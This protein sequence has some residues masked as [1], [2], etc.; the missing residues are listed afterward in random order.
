MNLLLVIII[1]IILIFIA[2]VALS[3]RIKKNSAPAMLE[4][5]TREVGNLIV[6]LNSALDNV[7]TISEERIEELKKCIESSEKLL[8]KPAVKRALSLV[9]KQSDETSL[10]VEEKKGEEKKS[11]AKMPQNLME[12]T[13][14][15]FS[16][17]YTKEEIAQI[18]QINRAEV[19]FLESL[20]R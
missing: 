12:K 14:H 20:N 17:G 9:N 8:K 2:Y 19:D 4:R 15:L 16:M 7:V 11:K 6:G 18:L 3:S 10:H 13:K 5:Y 1:N